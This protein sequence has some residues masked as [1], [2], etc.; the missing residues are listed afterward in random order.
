[1]EAR[2][3]RCVL[4]PRLPYTSLSPALPHTFHPPAPFPQTWPTA[5]QPRAHV[6]TA[7]AGAGRGMAGRG[8]EG[9]SHGYLRRRLPSCPRSF[10][11]L[12]SSKDTSSF[13]VTSCWALP[14]VPLSWPAQCLDKHGYTNTLSC[15]Y[16]SQ[17]LRRDC[18]VFS[19]PRV[20][21][22]VGCHA[23]GAR[24][25]GAAPGGGPAPRGQR[26]G[27][28]GAGRAPCRMQRGSRCAQLGTLE[29]Q[30]WTRGRALRPADR[31]AVVGALD[32]RR[33]E[34]SG[35]AGW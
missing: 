35:G 25:R 13:L 31:G 12:R 15:L 7:V 23:G 32:V 19:P 34:C 24:P 22:G 4:S 14:H 21:A 29:G 11:R 33:S 18:R 3:P 26:R 30:A 9:A 2:L 1:M 5:T 28:C 16:W 6:S 20:P 10:P 27:G 17:N 8:G